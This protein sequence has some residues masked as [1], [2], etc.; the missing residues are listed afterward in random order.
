MSVLPIME[1]VPKYAPIPMEAISAHVML[2]IELH[3]T[4]ILVMV[5]Y[6]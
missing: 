1:A 2:V 5:S 3:L 4:I 6:V